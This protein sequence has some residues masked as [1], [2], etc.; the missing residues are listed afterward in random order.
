MNFQCFRYLRQIENELSLPPDVEV[1]T[2]LHN[3]IQKTFTGRMLLFGFKVKPNCKL[4][5]LNLTQQED[6][7]C[8]STLA[9]AF[10]NSAAVN[11]N[12]GD[13]LQSTCNL[14]SE[15]TGTKLP[16]LIAFQTIDPHPNQKH[17]P[18]INAF[19]HDLAL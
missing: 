3:G 12:T 7:D 4:K 1:R 14:Q 5:A 16:T 6:G 15:T 13:I 9:Y 18:V 11:F 10:K 19:K 2:R 8:N 17:I